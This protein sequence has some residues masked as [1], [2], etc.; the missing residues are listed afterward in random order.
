[1]ILQDSIPAN[2]RQ[3][4]AMPDEPFRD[5]TDVYEAMV[6]WPKR[7][8]REEPFYR[9]VFEGAGIRI[10]RDRAFAQGQ[11]ALTPDPSPADGRGEQEA[12]GPSPACGRGGPFAGSIVDVA[13]GTGRHAAMFHSWG[14]RV[15]GADVSEA[16]IDRA[17][18]SFGQPEGLRWVVRGFDAPI[19]AEE[20]FD[21][22]I[23][24]G[25]SLALAPDTETVRRAIGR[26][27][28]AVRPGGVAVLHVL[29][30]WR[31]PEGPCTWQKCLRTTLPAGDVLVLKGVH[32]AGSRG[33]V[34]LVIAA[35]AL[36]TMV[37]SES[38]VL[39]GL[40]ASD[41]A[42]TAREAGAAQVRLLGGYGDQPYDRQQSTDL[43]VVA[44]K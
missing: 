21:A 14:L 4:T 39:L 10:E 40:E 16:M 5:L 42:Q 41:L 17:R 6:D 23:C 9:R 30:L 2:R 1:M 43:I 33:Y 37:T 29:N 20:P 19:D 24:V 8:A 44:E 18:T 7:L 35:A 28:C 31:L 13:C 15:E 26:M 36:G 22:A 3:P 34:E 32:R 25:N 12:L 11:S 38:A 27:L